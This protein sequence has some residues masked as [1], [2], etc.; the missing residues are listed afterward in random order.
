[1]RFKNRRSS[2]KGKRFILS[3]LLILLVGAGAGGFIL[4]FEGEKPLASLD[5]TGD[6][7]GNNATIQ[8]SVHDNKSGIRSIYLWAEQDGN[9]K[10]LHSNEYP[11]STYKSPVGP[12]E[13]IEEIGFDIK[14]QGFKEGPLTITLEATDFSLQGWFKGNKVTVIKEVSVDTKPPKIQIL[15]TEK[16]ISPGG[17]GI[18]IYKVSDKESIHGVTVNSKFNQGFLLGDGRDD[19][20]IA[21]FALPYDTA[22][23]EE[24]NITARDKAQNETIVPFSTTLKKARQKRDIINV[25]DGFLSRKIPEFQQYYPEMAGEFI[26]KYLYANSSVRKQNNKQISE[27]C[28]NSSP[29]RLWKGHFT[30]MA[31]SARAGFADHRTYKHNGEVVDHQ[32]HLGMDI[33]STRRAE[34]KAANNGKVV[35]GDYL[36]IYGNMVLLDH[37]QGVFSLYSHLSQINVTVGD[38]VK[39]GGVIGLTGTTGMAGG[40]HLHFSMLVHGTFV[41]PKEWWDKHWID[42]TIDEPIT[43]SKF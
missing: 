6:F 25:S 37:G 39:G 20:F 10:I 16:Y 36:G 28:S 43:D 31:G 23:I 11:R 4:F 29:E 13:E 8:Y 35:F 32:V 24:L 40:D 34:V 41:T 22:K 9:K 15:H 21:F 1:M 17:S 38:S 33:A 3:T 7:L 27:L 26:D 18:A 14:K 5:G 12:L 19:T 42:V 30:R 2:S